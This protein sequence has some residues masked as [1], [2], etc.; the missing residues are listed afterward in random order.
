MNKMV[1]KWMDTNEKEDVNNQRE[2]DEL[3]FLIGYEPFITMFP[4]DPAPGM[5]TYSVNTDYGEVRILPSMVAGKEDI[6]LL[7]RV[8]TAP[9][10]PPEES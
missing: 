2:M 10:L 9:R 8:V 4:G 5:N 3:F 1:K 7:V 6:K